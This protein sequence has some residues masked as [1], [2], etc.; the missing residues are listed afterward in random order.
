[1]I[2]K[3]LLLPIFQLPS[4]VTQNVFQENTMY[5]KI[6]RQESKNPIFQTKLVLQNAPVNKL[7]L[8]GLRVDNILLDN[9]TAKFDFMI[10]LEESGDTISGNIEFNDTLFETHTIKT[11]L[12]QWQLLVNNLYQNENRCLADIRVAFINGCENLAQ[13]ENEL[14][15]ENRQ[16]KLRTVKR[17]EITNNIG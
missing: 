7:D 5:L 14:L 9:G 4:P 12:G 11:M 6:P 10:L 13:K 3:L 16:N 17:K 2:L 1:M 15:N 8:E